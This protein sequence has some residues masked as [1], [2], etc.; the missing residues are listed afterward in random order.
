MNHKNRTFA[1]DG[2]KLL[3]MLLIVLHHSTYWKDIFHHGYMAVELFFVTSGYFLMR[4]LDHKPHM[5]AGTYMR[6]RLSRLYPHYLLS[7]VVM[8]LST[9][10]Y[11]AGTITLPM[12]LRSIPELLLVQNLGIFSGGVNYPCWYLSV[13]FFAG[14][15]IFLLARKLPRKWFNVLGAVCAVSSYSAILVYA[16]G[17]METFARIGVFYLPFWRGMAGLFCATL[18]YQSHA[19][20]QPVFRKFAR[21]FQVME[22]LSLG[23][24]IGLMF[25]PG[26]TD[27]PIL[28]LILLLLLCVGSEC[29]V[30]ERL[31]DN[32]FVAR[33]IHYEYAVFLN[34]AFVIGM[35]RKICQERLG[36]PPFINLPILLIALV[37]YSV[38]TQH[39]VSKA[40]SV[41][42]HRKEKV[43]RC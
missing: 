11:R 4:T 1:L 3:F 39:F 7:L 10:V 18:L 15:L 5:S 28:L 37:V 40:T 12:V 25:V 23:A 33:A 43:N 20:L 16:R 19:L 26:R 22:V 36:L 29:S 32:P 34:H 2:L 38:M 9:S 35:V 6:S 24:I 8:F 27:G 13:L 42:F 31:S 41:L 30:V 17:S 14:A 21:L